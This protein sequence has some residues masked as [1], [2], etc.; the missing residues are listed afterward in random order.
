MTLRASQV[1]GAVDLGNRQIDFPERA[2]VGQERTVLL[3]LGAGR[4]DHGSPVG[5]GQAPVG[6]VG[7]V[8]RHRPDRGGR[9]AEAALVQ[10]ENSA[11][12]GPRT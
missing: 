3:R 11:I 9:A 10:A 2:R 1:V 5:P 4:A 7:A 12:H 6:S 8:G